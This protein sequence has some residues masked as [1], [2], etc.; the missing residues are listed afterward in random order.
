[1]GN[2]SIVRP[3]CARVPSV[4]DN[5]L[6]V[7]GFGRYLSVIQWFSTV[8]S[9]ALCICLCA[10]Q[11][12]WVENCYLQ[13]FHSLLFASFLSVSVFIAQ[14]AFLCVLWA[15]GLLSLSVFLKHSCFL[16][17]FSVPSPLSPSPLISLS[18]SSVVHLLPCLFTPTLFP[19]VISVFLSFVLFWSSFIWAVY[20]VGWQRHRHTWG[21]T[22]TACRNTVIHRQTHT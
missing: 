2:A 7:G 9:K 14:R 13:L 20:M 17:L 5:A 18:F 3:L 10:H 1:M 8:L 22:H 4:P 11:G 6:Q 16:F 12:Q 21:H 19:A 15:S